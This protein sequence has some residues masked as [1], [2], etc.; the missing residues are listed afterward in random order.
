MYLYLP[1]T[2]TLVMGIMNGFVN[3]KEWDDDYP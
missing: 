2:F 1:Q 3:D